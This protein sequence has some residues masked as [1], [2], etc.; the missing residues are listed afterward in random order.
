MFN[1]KNGQASCITGCAEW[2]GH[3]SGGDGHQMHEPWEQLLGSA[4]WLHSVSGSFSLDVGT[5]G[6]RVGTAWRSAIDF[7][8][9]SALFTVPAITWSSCLNS[10]LFI[11]FCLLSIK[12]IFNTCLLSAL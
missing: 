9:R 1:I 6:V 3:H 4:S 5:G 7:A 8:Q 10:C 12:R 11:S 2:F